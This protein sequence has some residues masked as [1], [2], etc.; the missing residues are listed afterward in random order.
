[1]SGQCMGVESGKMQ[2]GCW[3]GERTCLTQAKGPG[4]LVFVSQEMQ[5]GLRNIPAPP[6][7]PPTLG[8]HVQTEGLCPVP[9]EDLVPSHFAKHN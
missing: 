2:G 1:M 4:G 8:W 6:Y 9:L 7:Y 3:S 5:E